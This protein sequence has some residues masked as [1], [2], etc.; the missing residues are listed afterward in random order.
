MTPTE[1]RAARLHDTGKPLKI[2]RLPVPTIRPTEVLVKVEACGLVQNLQNVIAEWDEVAPELPLPKLPAIFGLDATGVIESVGSQV[3]GFKPG[4][5]VYVNPGRYCGSCRAC[6]AGEP[7]SCDSFVLNGYFGL[8]KNGAQMFEDYPYGGLC[9][10][11]PAPQYSLVRLPDAVDFE[12]ATRLGYLGT[13]Y[14]GLIRANAG[15]GKT[16]L[17]NGITGTL[18]LGAVAVA[19]AL[20]V[21]KILGTAR[22]KDFF[23]KVQDMG[24]EGRIEI[25]E[26]GSEPVKEWSQRVTDGQGVDIVLDALA[27][28]APAEPLVEGFKS[29]NRGGRLV[30]IGAVQGDVPLDLFWALSN[31]ITIIGSSWFTT[32]Q[33][34]AMVDMAGAGLL[35][36]GFYE[37]KVYPLEQVNKAVDDTSSRHGGFTNY[38]IKM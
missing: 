29:L 20:G 30:D 9:E 21:K 3:Y 2:E 27:P 11:M 23:Q 22:N 35:D 4:D 26:S 33:S 16:L 13:A 28:G 32:Q 36:L 19:L 15:P 37:H 6:Q 17:I 1:M 31:D 34:Q 12:T 18:G 8:G 14:R 5:R 10:Y 7:V 24:P 38:V 25:L